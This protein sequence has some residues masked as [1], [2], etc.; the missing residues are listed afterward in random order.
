MIVAGIFLYLICGSALTSGSLYGYETYG[1]EEWWRSNNFLKF[2]SPGGKNYLIDFESGELSLERSESIEGQ[3]IAD[4][5]SPYISFV[6]VTFKIYDI[7]F[8]HQDLLYIPRIVEKQVQYVDRSDFIRHSLHSFVGPDMQIYTLT[9]GPSNITIDSDHPEKELD[10]LWIKT[11][12]PFSKWEHKYI[13]SQNGDTAMDITLEPFKMPPGHSIQLAEMDAGQ[14][15]D[16]SLLFANFNTPSGTGYLITNKL[17]IA[18]DRDTSDKIDQSYIA[19]TEPSGKVYDIYFK[20]D[21]SQYAARIVERNSDVDVNIFEP[22]IQLLSFVGPDEK[23]YRIDHKNESGVEIPILD[24]TPTTPSDFR[25]T[26]IVSHKYYTKHVHFIFSNEGKALYDRVDEDDSTKLAEQPEQLLNEVEVNGE[27][28]KSSFLTFYSPSGRIYYITPGELT[29]VA[30]G[31][32]DNS[33]SPYISFTLQDGRTSSIYYESSGATEM[34]FSASDRG[35]SSSL[36]MLQSFITP[37]RKFHKI[38]TTVENGVR[39]PFI[40]ITPQPKDPF[41]TR[42]VDCLRLYVVTSVRE[43]R[44]LFTWNGDKLILAGAYPL[45]RVTTG[46][47]KSLIG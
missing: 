6:W 37:D 22:I 5:T 39:I 27:F 11:L 15:K 25:I 28:A 35:N 34:K 3:E 30:K 31:T 32:H 9:Y 41:D 44:Y 7:F 17:N 45:K 21:G 4:V 24:S 29:A 33:N 40:D 16:L 10:N 13:F 14:L 18:I 42:Q 38:L 2:C 43:Y 47:L 26:F 20:Q 36:M 23:T 1:G 19:F 12:G 8:E 46:V